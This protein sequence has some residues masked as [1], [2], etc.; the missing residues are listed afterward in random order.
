MRTNATPHGDPTINAERFR[1]FRWNV[2]LHTNTT[3][4]ASA[5]KI[6]LQR[7]AALGA[8]ERHLHYYFTLT[9]RQ[10]LRL[11]TIRSA[12]KQFP[13]ERSPKS[14]L[15]INAGLRSNATPGSVSIVRTHSIHVTS[16]GTQYSGLIT[17]QRRPAFKRNARRHVYHSH[18]QNPRDLRWNAM[19]RPNDP[20]TT[21]MQLQTRYSPP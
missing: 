14:T 3:P 2:R 18:A 5:K 9:R 4:Y 15:S 17:L 6:A 19:Q 7:N 20:G 8:L 13:L 10:S 21:A 12:P 11:R 16:V 1:V